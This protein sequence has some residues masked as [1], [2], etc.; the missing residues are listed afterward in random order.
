MAGHVHGHFFTNIPAEE[1]PALYRHIAERLQ[2]DLW[3]D[4]QWIA[5]YKRLQ[6]VAIKA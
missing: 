5:D 2:N 3:V 4:G 1:R 6:V